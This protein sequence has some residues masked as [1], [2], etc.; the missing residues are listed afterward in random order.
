MT[1]TAEIT[2]NRPLAFA[3]DGVVKDYGGSRVVDL[4]QDR[5]EIPLGE[6]VAFTGASGSGKSTLLRMM[7]GIVPPDAGEITVLGTDIHALDTVEQQRFRG[8]NI[9]M[10]HQSPSP[11][12]NFTVANNLRTTGRQQPVSNAEI[13][14]LA[15]DVG[16]AHRLD[17]LAGQ[18]SGGEQGRLALASAL[19]N[20]RPII[21]TDEPDGPLDSGNSL[22]ILQRLRRA[23]DLGA[24]VVM[25]THDAEQAGPFLDRELVMSNGKLI[26][27]IVHSRK[28]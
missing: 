3:V 12:A 16:I 22:R 26:Q 20:N 18:L 6:F 2:A 10:S 11:I 13:V 8:A 9:G 27:D 23:A 15:L 25:V 28:A 14:D 7:I 5:I 4:E 24:T 19:V 17:T 1:M 21:T